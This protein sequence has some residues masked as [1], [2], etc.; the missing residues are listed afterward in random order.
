MANPGRT[1]TFQAGERK[2]QT[3]NVDDE[4][5]RQ[6]Q[7]PGGEDPSTGKTESVDEAVDRMSGNP[8]EATNAGRQAQ[9]TDHMNQ[10]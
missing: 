8:E 3:I 6:P 2:G 4:P 5:K 1:I 9:S 10:Y 7:A